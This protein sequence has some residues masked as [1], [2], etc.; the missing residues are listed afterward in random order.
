MQGFVVQRAGASG[1]DVL[2]FIYGEG[3]VSS[4]NTAM[5]AKKRMIDPGAGFVLPYV[6]TVQL[7]A[8]ETPQDRVWLFVEEGM[9]RGFDNG[10]DGR[11]MAGEKPIAMLYASET[12]GDYQVN[13][14]PDINETCLSIEAE[15]GVAEYTLTFKYRDRNPDEEL[16]LF[17][18]KTRELVTISADS[19]VYHFH[20]SATDNGEKRFQIITRKTEMDSEDKEVRVLR[21]NGNTFIDSRSKNTAEIRLFDLSGRQLQ[22]T[23]RLAPGEIRALPSLPGGVYVVE[24][25][26][27]NKKYL[28][29]VIAP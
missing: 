16:L 26:A 24:I 4:T 6:A 10:Y 8:G 12:D 2:S 25:T 19:S 17:D 21:I 3:K 15:K 5:L 7:S 11:K 23:L 27:K 29:K 9:T 20:A 13:S 18:T 1:S 14:I 22:E 28:E